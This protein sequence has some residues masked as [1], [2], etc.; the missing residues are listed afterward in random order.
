MI[1]NDSKRH[2][3][4]TSQHAP[5]IFED[6]YTHVCT[7]HTCICSEHTHTHTHTFN[8][9]ESNVRCIL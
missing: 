8:V 7:P 3:T 9:D 1:K 2:P 4:S 5:H 6:E